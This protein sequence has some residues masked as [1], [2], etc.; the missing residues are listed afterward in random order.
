MMMYKYTSILIVFSVFVLFSCDKDDDSYV[1]LEITTQADNVMVTSLETIEIA[2]LNND[3]NVPEDGVLTFTSPLNGV[4]S[5]DKNGT[6][7]D[8]RDDIIIY[9]PENNFGGT[10]T[11]E[12]TIC[13]ELGNGCKTEVVTITVAQGSPVTL[14]LEQFPFPLLSRYNFFENTLSELDP[15][16]GVLPFEPITPLF[17][18]YAEK[19]R[20]VYV[21][22]DTKASYVADDKAFDFPTGSAL[23][24]VFYYNNV[25]PNNER[26]IIETRIMVKKASGWE[27]AEYIWNEEQTEATLDQA[28]QGSFTEVEWVQNGETRFVN[29]RIPSQTE[30]IVCHTNSGTSI[31]LGFKPQN[32]NASFSFESGEANQIDQL[33][34]DGFLEDNVPANITTVV[35]WEDINA[36]LLDRSRAYLDITCGNCHSD[37]G[38]ADYRLLRLLY[39]N[40]E[41]NPDN[42]GVCVDADTAIPGFPG[43]KLFEPGDAANSINLYRM[44]IVDSQYT[45]PQ[46]GRNL[47]HDEGVQ[48]IEE[49]INSMEINCD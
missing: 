25:L 48:L 6:N 41:N 10:D 32:I 17:T 31:P 13:N 1:P 18:D 3:T 34:A 20:Y 26:R 30:C 11:F 24:K 45:M 37:G 47:T 27:F 38:Q 36:S 39:S 5:L 9:D 40:T 42:L 44:E 22:Q 28:G 35:D 43:T 23:I 8:V 2:I 21:P 4:V 33:I 29:Y 49:W 15:S 16:F 12:Y 7:N 46:I 19:A 14:D